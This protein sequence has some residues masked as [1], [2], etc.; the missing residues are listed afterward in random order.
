MNRLPMLLLLLSSVCWG[1]TDGPR[2]GAQQVA[3]L[4]AQTRAG[5]ALNR[6]DLIDD[7]LTRLRLVAPEHPRT[8]L[9]EMR[10]ALRQ[11]DFVRVR[12]LHDRFRS[13]KHDSALDVEKQARLLLVLANEQ[14]QQSLQQARLA[15]MAGRPEEAYAGMTAIFGDAPPTLELAVE[16]W[17]LRS[18][19][20]GQQA[21]AITA[22]RELDAH[23]P[24]NPPVR[25]LLAN[26]LF[27]AGQDEAALALLAVLGRNPTATDAAAQREFEYLAAQPISD[28]TLAGWQSF[29]DRYA[30]GRFADEARQHLERG[31]TLIADPFWRAGQRGLE[32]VSR[33]DDEAAEVQ[34]RQALR[35]HPQ[36]PEFLGGLGRALMRPG[37]RPQAIRYFERAKA[38]E[39]D[40][41]NLT[42]WNDLIEATR[43]WLTLEQADLALGQNN[44]AKAKTLYTAALRRRPDSLFARA[45]LAR[46]AED[47]GRLEQAEQ[48]YL[49]ILA[50]ERDNGSAIRGLVRIYQAQST[51]RALAFIESL[52]PAQRRAFASLRND[53][54]LERYKSIADRALQAQDAAIAS[55]AL[56]QARTLA[57]DD[58]WLAY[59]LA[60]VLHEQGRTGQADAV[61]ADLLRR[62]A[63]D[64]TSRYAHG[65]YL[66]AA[67]RDV[68]ALATLRAVPESQ[69]SEDMQALA[70]RVQRR[71]LLARAEK[72]RETGREHAAIEI[73]ETALRDNGGPPED[74]VML[75]NWAEARGEIGKALDYL[76]QALVIDGTHAGAR[77]SRIEALVTAGRIPEARK[78]LERMPPDLA[79]EDFN[80]QRRLA[81]SWAAVGET[82]KA[83]TLLTELERQQRAPDPLLRR[84]T[85]RLLRAM[86]PRQAI[87]LYRQAMVDAELLDADAH[88]PAMT[89]ASRADAEDDWLV[90]S[91]RS[92]LAD[93]YQAQN[94][95][96]TLQH[97]FGWRNDDGTPGISEL[98]TNTTLL[99]LEW[100]AAGQRRFL[101]AERI[102]LD[103][104]TLDADPNFGSCRE[105]ALCGGKTQQADAMMLAGGVQTERMA[106][107]AGFSQG[108]EID[109]VFAGVT[110]SGGLGQLG[111]SLTASRRPM[112]N[113]LL[114]YGGSLDPGTGVRWGAVT[115]N[116]ASLGL[117]WDEGGAHGVWAN[118]GHHWLRGEKVADNRRLTAMTGYYY[119]WLDRIDQRLRSGLTFIHFAYER[120]LSGHTLGQGGYWSPQQY[121]SIGLPVSYAWRNPDWSVLL[122]GG[123]SW[124]VSS[125]DDSR[126][127]PLDSL[128]GRFAEVI[129]PQAAAE[130]IAGSTSRGVSYRLQGM[131]ERRLTDHFVLG[132]ALNWVYS[133]DYAPSNALLFVRYNFAPWRGDLSWPVEPLQ[134]YAAFR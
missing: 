7:A 94:T 115:A 98:Q 50:L 79:P 43:Y 11:Q 124:S 116:G 67:E 92:D 125:A 17:R 4:L 130:E 26:L 53:L 34:L 123:V 54:L 68:A 16:Y 12:S 109:N 9:A 64:P 22:L 103:A 20:P 83:R 88:S 46:V 129:G 91:L 28:R 96:L 84:D 65:L 2:D 29:L 90:R 24:G 108:F 131:F 132:G 63:D 13:A 117:S 70:T 49:S 57:P 76:Q 39:D 114:S 21:Q 128:N 80:G 104:G 101:R 62:Q 25:Q 66:A 78:A 81:N 102:D 8:L 3:W 113:S 37:H 122:E 69:W 15:A 35:R 6:D 120:E 61:F 32:L 85:A 134:P 110:G 77:L 58:P 127:Y 14:T 19:R 38:N 100:P 97:H 86:N 47:E 10:L 112:S 111:W 59:R 44:H 119:K 51:D 74:F 30:G 82:E 99:H 121:N 133:D 71:Q 126:R 55:E 48:D 52:A 107:D 60:N 73:I 27:D 33:G 41:D 106:V 45:G 87:G 42:K 56:K 75:A 31:R 18:A 40:I 23:Y 93:L 5:E 118:L 89:R 1:Q 72:L 36:E 95:T 105:T